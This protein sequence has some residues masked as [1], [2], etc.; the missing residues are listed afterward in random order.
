MSA[1]RLKPSTKRHNAGISMAY[2]CTIDTNT[3]CYR[4]IDG[5][6]VFNRVKLGRG[7]AEQPFDV[8]KLSCYEKGEDSMAGKTGYHKQWLPWDELMPQVEQ[9]LAEGKEVP[10]IAQRLGIKKDTLWKRLNLNKKAQTSE[11]T[12]GQLSPAQSE[13]PAL[14]IV[15]EKE[16]TVKDVLLYEI[17][18]Q[19]DF[20]SEDEEPIPYKVFDLA[21]VKIQ[22]IAAALAEYRAEQLPAFIALRLV[23]AIGDIELGVE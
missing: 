2:G 16:I 9:M 14:D 19:D 22:L 5:K 3:Y 4:L 20:T 13:A 1:S 11:P 18:Q 6:Q 10:E 17:E 23:K 7:W 8:T 12:G 15:P 21:P